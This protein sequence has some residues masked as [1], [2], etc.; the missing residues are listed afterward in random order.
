MKQVKE[1]YKLLT[2]FLSR[3]ENIDERKQLFDWFDLQSADQIPEKQFS[4]IQKNVKD[5][6]LTEIGGI[7]KNPLR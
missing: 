6:L 2:R 3:S 7:E 5:R 4:T 1:L